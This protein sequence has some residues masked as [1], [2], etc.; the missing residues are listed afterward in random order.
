MDFVKKRV[1][2]KILFMPENTEAVSEGE[3]Q[4]R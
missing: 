3:D 1:L 4:K 2:G